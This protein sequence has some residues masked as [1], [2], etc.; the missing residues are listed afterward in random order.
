MTA[1]MEV[2]PLARLELCVAREDLALDVASLDGE[3]V[4]SSDKSSSESSVEGFTHYCISTP[5]VT[6]ATKTEPPPERLEMYVASQD[7]REVKHLKTFLKALCSG[8]CDFRC[9]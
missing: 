8:A 6:I 7:S 1:T 9:R 5:V 3:N 4:V 2:L